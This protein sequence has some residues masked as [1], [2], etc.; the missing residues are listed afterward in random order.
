MKKQ[1]IIKQNQLAWD[2]KA[3]DGNQWSTPVSKEEINQ[4]REGIF[5]IKLTARKYVPRNWFPE[6]LKNTKILCLASA[7]GQ[8]GPIL[9]AAGAIVTVFDI[10]SNQL[11]L[12][13]KIAKENNLIISTIQGEMTHLECFKN[14][15]FDLIFCPV[16][17]T[18]IPDVLP[19]F[20]ESFRVLKNGGKFLFGSVNPLIYLF[21][22]DKYDKGIFEVSNNLPFNSFDELTN[23]Q[24]VE[25]INNKEPIEYSHTLEKLIGGQTEVGFTIEDFYEDIDQDE[26]C[27]YTCKY[28]AT[29]AVK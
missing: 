2:K 25:F 15:Y 22:N 28:F 23:N 4:A 7:G 6:N 12:D 5:N 9:A 16:S 8:Q 3:T 17:V 1:D 21:D 27:N 19:V 29:K 10:S 24:I 13:E 18:Y 20:K 26:I 11:K 14:N